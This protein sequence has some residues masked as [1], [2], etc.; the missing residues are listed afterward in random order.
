MAIANRMK[1]TPIPVV[2][3]V[4]PWRVRNTTTMP[5]GKIVPLA[6]IPLLREDACMGR[7]TVGANMAETYE[8]L[9][10][11]MYVRFSVYF[12][13]HLAMERFGQSTDHYERSFAGQPK[14]DDS[15]AAVIPYIETAAAP[16]TATP[17]MRYL[18]LAA[19]SGTM[20]NTSYW[21]TYTKIVNWLRRNKS[22]DLDPIDRLA[23]DLQPAFWDRSAVSQ[24]VP[25]FD[26]GMIAGELPLSVVQATLPVDGLGVL[27]ATATRYGSALTA[28]T[29]NGAKTFANSFSSSNV[30]DGSGAAAADNFLIETNSEGVPQ[31]KATLPTNGIM[32]SLANIDQARELVNWA[33]MREQYEGITEAWKID[34]LMSG[35]HI[36]EQRHFEPMLLDSKLVE[37]RQLKR[38][39]M[40][41]ASLEDG[42]ANGVVTAE[43]SLNL[44]Q[45]RFGGV[46]MVIAEAI[47]EQLYERQ[48]D[49]WFTAQTVADLPNYKADVLNPMPVVAALNKEI[50]SD[51]DEPNEVFGWARRNWRWADGQA[52][53]GGDLY[54]PDADAATTVA[55]RVIYPTDVE[56]PKLSEEFYVSTTLGRSPFIDQ[57]KDPFLV[58]I[59]GELRISGLTVIGAVHESEAN[60]QEM[61]DS[62]PPFQP[63]NKE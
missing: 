45:Q 37:V 29:S 56:N 11:R 47:P 8:V 53:V 63:V 19:K 10:N 2:R 46:L 24:I 62:T 18:G 61:R 35:Y 6:A 55:R 31:V 5:P 9:M 49:P 42:A 21:E 25:D 22:K 13:S 32:V 27:N 34:T 20:I 41:G 17:L 40:D 3:Q 1:D 36:D 59:G 23:Q 28:S 39:A 58:G 14:N 50:D 4:R 44:P 57:E 51:H 15:G 30:G 16:A 33:R 7:L 52:R 60:Y 48:P 54:A 43:L 26:D 12:V 38:M